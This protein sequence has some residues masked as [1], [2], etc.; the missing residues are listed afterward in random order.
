MAA[1]DPA[2]PR[3]REALAP[4]L[5]L[6]FGVAVHCD[7]R[8]VGPSELAKNGIRGL[9]RHRL[10]EDAAPLVVV[11]E[12]ATPPELI[13][14][15]FRA[16]ARDVLTLAEV[17]QSLLP[18]L[19]R[20]L[21]QNGAGLA[22]ERE[23]DQLAAELGKRAR[24]VEA[25]LERLQQSYDQTLKALVSALDL[26]EQETAN[27]SLR[28]ALYSLRLALRLGVPEHSLRDLYHGALLHDIGKIG[29]PDGVLLKPGSLTEAEWQIMRT[30]PQLGGEILRA[31]SFL[32][33]ASDVPLCHHEAWD[34]SGYPRGMRS[35][36]IPLHA[37]IFA[38][39]DTYDALR[40]ERPYKRALPHGESLV[41]LRE[42]AGVRLDPDIV[43]Q[44]GGE[45]PE[46]WDQLAAGNPDGFEA[47]LRT[48]RASEP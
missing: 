28:V 40:S 15:C 26:R 4:E 48:A 2:L 41:Q 21:E 18:V 39:V 10:R 29:I 27:H 12:D 8:L 6:E 17:R 24:Q 35:R 11:V 20:V 1:E 36:E 44:F 3:L 13:R 37:R 5:A 43:E 38:V 19:R 32:A 16:G 33:P 7:V 34:G 42:D 30:H 25:A 9:R 46:I 47:V 22:L 45:S 14:E 23:T 31:I